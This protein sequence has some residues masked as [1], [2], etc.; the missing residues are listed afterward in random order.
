MNFPSR[1][2][3][4][5]SGVLALAV[6]LILR[7]KKNPVG[8]RTLI[9]PRPPAFPGQNI[10][11]SQTTNRIVFPRS[12]V[13]GGG[14]GASGGGSVGI[15][16]V[17]TIGSGLNLI[18]GLFPARNSNAPYSAFEI[19]S[20]RSLVPDSAFL[21]TPESIR[22]PGYVSP[23]SGPGGSD[24]YTPGFYDITTGGLSGVS[25]PFYIRSPDPEP[26][27]DPNFGFGDQFGTGIGFDFGGDGR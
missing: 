27:I 24:G 10:P 23:Y 17:K 16:L 19:A 2:T 21:A 12:G 26:A 13:N 5:L 25:A 15:D 6:W 7:K 3:I 14:G 4:L 22:Y 11:G 20:A 8:A 18:R 9:S 1:N